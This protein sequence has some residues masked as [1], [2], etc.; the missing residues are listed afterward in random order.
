M[1]TWVNKRFFGISDFMGDEKRTLPEGRRNKDQSMTATLVDIGLIIAVMIIGAWAFKID[2]GIGSARTTQEAI[3]KAVRKAN[4]VHNECHESINNLQEQLDLV[5]ARIV[6]IEERNND[7][8]KQ[9]LI[10]LPA[11]KH[12]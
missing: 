9:I 12:E 2:F 1:C 5:N 3:L 6:Q 8:L 7:V 4:I 11:T 10:R